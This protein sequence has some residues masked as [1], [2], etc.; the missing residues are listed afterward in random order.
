MCFGGSSK[1]KKASPVDWTATPANVF[2]PG[3]DPAVQ[4]VGRRGSDG[5]LMSWREAS[6]YSG[7]R[8]IAPTSLFE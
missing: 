4:M 2:I 3:V 6:A 7:R 1:T 5:P 8:G